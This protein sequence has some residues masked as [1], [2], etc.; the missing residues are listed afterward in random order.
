MHVTSEVKG[1]TEQCLLFLCCRAKLIKR[2]KKNK[3]V[4]WIFP[5]VVQWRLD[6]LGA[7]Y[8]LMCYYKERTMLCRK[9]FFRES[10]R[11][12]SDILLL[13]PKVN[14]ILLFCLTEAN[15]FLHWHQIR[16]KYEEGA[17]ERLCCGK[18]YYFTEVQA[19]HWGWWNS[20]IAP[21][22]LGGR[23]CSRIV[24]LWFF[25]CHFGDITWRYFFITG[26]SHSHAFKPITLV[27]GTGI[28]PFQFA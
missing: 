13:C 4:L 9:D 25:S 3:S 1:A 12:Q 2:N 5:V 20:L 27:D 19:S 24:F 16:G 10:K 26:F 6:M 17:G 22:C 15:D 18:P 23:M 21:M 28:P 11:A 8:N 7:D 14:N